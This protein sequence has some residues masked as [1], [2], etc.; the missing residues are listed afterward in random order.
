M[1]D[2]RSPDVAQAAHQHILLACDPAV[3]ESPEPLDVGLHP[4]W[5]LTYGWAAP[6]S[7]HWEGAYVDDLLLVTISSPSLDL[8]L[9]TNAEQEHQAIVDRVRARYSEVGLIRKAAKAKEKEL[10][11]EAWGC[12]I[13]STHRQ[14][15][16]SEARRI[17]VMEALAVASQCAA[18][19]PSTMEVLIG[20][21]TYCL[22][23][24]RCA[25]CCLSHVYSWLEHHKGRKDAVY[26]PGRVRDE[27]LMAMLTLPFA[28][29]KLTS[30][31][32][33]I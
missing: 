27:L 17:K 31:L 3:D 16:V 1:G 14:V 28:E 23:F 24:R 12:V 30:T 5:W 2:S 32:A 26:I 33:P 25:L 15:G 11:A 19:P 21:V 18:L 9:G 13:S 10:D 7:I 29:S 8:A 22:L 4:S 6:T 20:H